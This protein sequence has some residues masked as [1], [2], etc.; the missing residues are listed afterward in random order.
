M[1]RST[2]CF[3]SIV[4]F[5]A[6]AAQAQQPSWSPPAPSE[7]CPSKWGAAD[8]RGSM[9]HMK[10]AAVLAATKLIRTGEVIELGH[11]LNGQMPFSGVRRFDLH[12]KRTFMN[13]QS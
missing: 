9:N 13:P 11:L 2:L 6:A 7:R 3:A 1:S 4:V 8:E 12:T 5:A 10:P